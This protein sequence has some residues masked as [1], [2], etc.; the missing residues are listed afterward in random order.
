[1]PLLSCINLSMLRAEDH[2]IKQKCNNALYHNTMPSLVQQGKGGFGVK[3][4]YF[5]RFSGEGLLL[6]FFFLSNLL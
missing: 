1:M 4:F 3:T 5:L 2:R 6:A